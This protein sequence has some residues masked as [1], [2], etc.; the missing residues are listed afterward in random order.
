MFQEYLLEQIRGR[1]PAKRESSIKLFLP[2]LIFVGF[3]IIKRAEQSVKR[4]REIAP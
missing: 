1:A 4:A 2:A 3:E